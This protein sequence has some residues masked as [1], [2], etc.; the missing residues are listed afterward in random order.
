MNYQ[1]NFFYYRPGL[2]DDNIWIYASLFT[3]LLFLNT[4]GVAF[5]IIFPFLSGVNAIISW[6]VILVLL[7][8][9]NNKNKELFIRIEEDKIEYFCTEHDET[10]SIYAH[11]ITKITTRFRELRIHTNERIH[12]LDLTIIH[13]RKKRWEIKELIHKIVHIK[14]LALTS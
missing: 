1:L 9:N 4:L 10:V 6:V 13:K 8:V 2:N 11:D 7:Q 5:N 3:L 12:S 14:R